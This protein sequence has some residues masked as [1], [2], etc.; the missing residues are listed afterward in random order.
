MDLVGVV[1]MYSW[2]FMLVFSLTD[3]PSKVHSYSKCYNLAENTSIP[4]AL[5]CFNNHATGSQLVI[6]GFR[7]TESSTGNCQCTITSDNATQLNF[8]RYDGIQLDKE[9]G[10][11]V[12]FQ[13]GGKNAPQNCFVEDVQIPYASPATVQMENL[14]SAN[15]NY[16]IFVESDA[17]LNISCSGDPMPSRTTTESP[18][19]T[20]VSTTTASTTTT[21]QVTS[22][23]I[24]TTEEDTTSQTT[25]TTSTTMTQSSE[26]LTSTSAATTTPTTTQQ[27][28]TDVLTTVEANLPSTTV[29]TEMSQPT[30]K[31]TT[32]MDMASTDGV[33][34]VN[35]S[36]SVTEGTTT[37]MST[38]PTPSETTQRET[39]VVTTTKDTQT[40]TQTSISNDNTVTSVISTASTNS[41]DQEITTT[42]QQ[43]STTGGEQ[44]T[45]TAT[46]TSPEHT[47]A[48]G[49][50]GSSQPSTNIVDTTTTI[51]VSVNPKSTT[52][53]T[54][55]TTS[56]QVDKGTPWSGIIPAIL[57]G[58]IIFVALIYAFVKWQRSREIKYPDDGT[59]SD[60]MNSTEKFPGMG[61]TN[62][63]YDAYDEG[64]EIVTDFPKSPEI[65]EME[66]SQDE[67]DP[68]NLTKGPFIRYNVQD[69]S[70]N[71]GSLNHRSVNE[72]KQ[73]GM[74]VYF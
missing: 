37:T 19:T 4:V 38:T 72:P 47:T 27:T 41:G 51:L 53:P 61:E 71:N 60:S 66:F 23:P 67:L 57:L 65:I 16:C 46:I 30:T 59:F 10:S 13:V 26:S 35:E 21:E 32:T 9:C 28:T 11:T 29:T 22:E 2:I 8:S 68:K 15:T 6:D 12:I 52:V 44:D 48:S 63:G 40:T 54:I 34:T 73:N 62:F 33:T 58:V 17:T 5:L 56:K 64:P 70:K 42:V 18:S 20:I 45:T 50:P 36:S 55:L 39:T 25:V 74:D 69:Y 49:N 14:L 43:S 31:P 1:D 24:A 3:F 7:A